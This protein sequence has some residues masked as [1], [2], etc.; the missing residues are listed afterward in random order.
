MLPHPLA[1]T[2]KGWQA[3]TPSHSAKQIRM[4]ALSCS[5]GSTSGR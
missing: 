3:T 4:A 2:A 1:G 5:E